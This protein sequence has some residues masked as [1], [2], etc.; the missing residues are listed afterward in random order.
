MHISGLRRAGGTGVLLVLLS[1]AAPA[2]Y[3]QG[4][5]EPHAQGLTVTK[6]ATY[7]TPQAPEG[8]WIDSANNKYVAMALTGEIQK[9]SPD[10]VQS[11][12]ATMPLAAP[13][14][15][16]CFGFPAII[17]NAYGDGQ[18]NLFV[19]V[20]SCDPA[21]SGLWKVVIATGAMTKVAS[22]PPDALLNGTIVDGTRVLVTDSFYDLVWQAPAD[23]TGQPLTVWK[24]D[25]CSRCR[26]ALPSRG[27]TG[28]PSSTAPPTW[29]S[30]IPP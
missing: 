28:S 29:R 7:T 12:I 4:P 18:G 15:T 10:G 16:V 23:G 30:P 1:L 11:T 24:D 25:P 22:A 2:A 26:P 17:G 6:V 14:G 13:P 27:R 21:N 9:I 5:P 20:H 8:V 3:A 19:G